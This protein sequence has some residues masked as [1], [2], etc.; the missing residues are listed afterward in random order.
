MTLKKLL[1]SAIECG[2]IEASA[3][4]G[5]V[6]KPN[7]R[8]NIGVVRGGEIRFPV[9]TVAYDRVTRYEYEIKEI[10]EEFC[11]VKTTMEVRNGGYQ[12]YRD[13]NSLQDKEKNLPVTFESLSESLHGTDER[14]F[15]LEIKYLGDDEGLVYIAEPEKGRLCYTETADKL[16]RCECWVDI[17]WERMNESNLDLITENYKTTSWKEQKGQII[18]DMPW[19]ADYDGNAYRVDENSIETQT[20]EDILDYVFLLCGNDVNGYFIM[21]IPCAITMYR[22]G[23]M[24]NEQ[25]LYEAGRYHVRGSIC[26]YTI[27]WPHVDKRIQGLDIIDIK[28]KRSVGDDAFL[29]RL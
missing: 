7:I 24:R 27:D 25:V 28:T 22:K 8:R 10:N 2:L 23:N 15:S 14:V 20:S 4:G 26:D 21:D 18:E 17:V 9:Y 13:W 19:S 12:I 29:D 3:H 6:W 16:L 5:R 1:E 11:L